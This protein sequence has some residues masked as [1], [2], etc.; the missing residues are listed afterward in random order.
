MGVYIYKYR[1][2][3]LYIVALAEKRLN[4]TRHRKMP[5][6]TCRALVSLVAFAVYLADAHQGHHDNDIFASDESIHYRDHEGGQGHD[7]HD[8]WCGSKH[9]S[10]Q[11]EQ[12]QQLRIE[13]FRHYTSFDPQHQGDG[14]QRRLLPTAC[15]ELCDQ[16]IEIQIRL[17]LLVVETDD[18]PRVPHPF[19]AVQ[20]LQQNDWSTVDWGE[21]SSPD[22]ITVLFEKNMKVL[23]SAFAGTPFNFTWDGE[24]SLGSGDQWTFSAFEHRAEISSELGS[25]DLRVLDVFVANQPALS[26]SGFILGMATPA[27]LQEKG[28]GDGVY[29]RYDVLTGGGLEHG[30][31]DLGYVLVHEVGEF[32]LPVFVL[33]FL[34]VLLHLF[35]VLIHL[36]YRTLVGS[37]AYLR[38][39]LS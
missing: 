15:E 13:A 30:G 7:H 9:L 39:T 26:Q 37:F 29:V 3:A 2:A 20:Q 16:C 36:I 28:R 22:E 11:E 1:G 32:A 17:N 35:V 23:N 4:A 18:G 6:L 25:D 10:L 21:F 34:G 19:S 24:Y 14:N 27:S 8:D 5:S 33:L 12:M 38:D 31:L